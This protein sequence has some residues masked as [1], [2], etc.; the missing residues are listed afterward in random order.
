[1]LAETTELA[2]LQVFPW[3]ATPDGLEPSTPPY[4]GGC[5]PRLCD[6]GSA[7]SSALSLQFGLFFSLR[8]PSLEGL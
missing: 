2:N 6:L 5:A 7:L 3:W 1:M 4:H 8:H